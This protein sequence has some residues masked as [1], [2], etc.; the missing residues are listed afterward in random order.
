[1]RIMATAWDGGPLL[2]EIPIYFR[3]PEIRQ[4]IAAKRLNKIVA[5]IQLGIINV[6]K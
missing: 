6:K 1:M 4:K 2:C 5:G 3:R